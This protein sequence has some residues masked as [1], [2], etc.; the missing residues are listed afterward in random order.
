MP[1][2]IGAGEN[3]DLPDSLLSPD[4]QLIIEF[5]PNAINMHGASGF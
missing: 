1:W 5:R 3:P 4:L 2:T